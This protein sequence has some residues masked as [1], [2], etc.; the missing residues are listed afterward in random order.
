M[1]TLSVTWRPEN[2]ACF[3]IH[4]T[5]RLTWLSAHG[6]GLLASGA[7]FGALAPLMLRGVEWGFRGLDQPAVF[8]R[9]LTALEVI[10]AG[11]FVI[12][13]VI[14]TL[15]YELFLTAL[16]RNYLEEMMK[17]KGREP[18]LGHRT[19]TLTEDRVTCQGD[20]CRLD[21]AA[22]ECLGVLRLPGM[23]VLCFPPQALDVMLPEADLSQNE[24]LMVEEWVTARLAERKAE[25]R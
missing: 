22:R 9:P 12:M 10:L 21:I 1:I 23:L 3:L 16:T 17:A 25:G 11:A 7:I 2:F 14:L 13:G 8:W 4:M 24:R 5:R 20:G 19:I 6:W 15:L 18:W